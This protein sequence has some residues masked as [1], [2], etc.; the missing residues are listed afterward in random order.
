MVTNFVT[1]F[2]SELIHA[3]REDQFRPGVVGNPFSIKGFFPAHPPGPRPLPQNRLPRVGSELSW[4]MPKFIDIQCVLA[5][6]YCSFRASLHHESAWE[7]ALDNR[8]GAGRAGRHQ[9]HRHFTYRLARTASPARRE[10]TR[11]KPR[12]VLAPAGALHLGPRTGRGARK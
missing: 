9:Q 3:S 6:C 1:F 10:A 11:R 2:N 7:T 8:H 4:D 12:N 5:C